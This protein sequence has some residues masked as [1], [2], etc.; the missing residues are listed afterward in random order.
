MKYKCVKQYD[1]TDCAAACIATIVSQYGNEISLGLI[2]EQAHTDKTGTTLQ[3]IVEAADKNGFDATAVECLKCINLNK[4]DFPCI[5]HVVLE[6]GFHHYIVLHKIEKNKILI[7]DPATGLK[8]VDKEDFLAGKFCGDFY[9]DNI[10]VLFKKNI[11]KWVH[12]DKKI[13]YDF[14]FLL[15]KDRKKDVLKIIL[16]SCFITLLNL[17]GAV[18]YKILVDYLIPNQWV[19]SLIFFSL[20]FVCINVVKNFCNAFQT[21]KT[22]QLSK[23]IN[24]SLAQDFFGHIINLPLSFHETRKIGDILSRIDDIAN[25]QNIIISSILAVPISVLFIMGTCSAVALISIWILI[26]V[27]LIYICYILV[28]FRFANK[29]ESYNSL[30]VRQDSK[31]LSFLVETLEGIEDVKKSAAK[32]KWNN[33]FSSEYKKLQD[34]NFKLVNTEN[35]QYALK[36]FLAF[37]GEI[38]ILAIGGYEVIKGEISIG[39][40]VSINVLIGYLMSPVQNIVDLQPKLHTAITSLKRIEAI[41]KIDKEKSGCVEIGNINRIE[42]C[43]AYFRYGINP[44]CLTSINLTIKKGDI[45]AIIGQSGSGKTTLG[46]ILAN[47]YKVSKGE[48]F[49]NGINIENI[50]REYYYNTVSYV[51]SNDYVF[52]GSIRQNLT[53]NSEVDDKIIEDTMKI[54]YIDD[55]IKKLPN[56]LDT[57]LEENGVNISKGQRQRIILARALLKHPQLLILDEATTNIDEKIERQIYINLRKYFPDM[58]QVI[59]THNYRLLGECNKIYNLKNG[60]IKT[61]SIKD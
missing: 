18:Y 45:I 49:I 11:K 54:V 36:L 35:Y 10:L 56:G 50:N 1:T 26:Y 55:F 39:D 27:L 57:V 7:A 16:L 44:F 46:K 41:N 2:R 4:L 33:L 38:G 22:L 3:G 29:Y 34:Y 5:A 42:V 32:D 19:N 14:F 24:N 51:S 17:F 13:A 31:V 8:R 52:S 28:A 47:L 58:M 43:K 20:L 6:N 60:E 48:I 59:I 61:V 23:D 25:I 12:T 9:W 40:L 37:V 21:K 53:I 15:I 30:L